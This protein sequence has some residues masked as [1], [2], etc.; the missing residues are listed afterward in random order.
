MG[1]IQLVA[2]RFR[3]WKPVR[4]AIRTV[5]VHRIVKVVRLAQVPFLK[6]LDALLRVV[7][8]DQRLVVMGSPL[9]R[10]ADNAAYFFLYLS[11]HS[12]GQILP[13]WITG[14]KRIVTLLRERGYSAELRW[15]Q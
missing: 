15:T 1:S 6:L 11:D 5:G 9:D 3:R 8:R 10:F 12:D 13:V 4:R 2:S 14:S 7:R